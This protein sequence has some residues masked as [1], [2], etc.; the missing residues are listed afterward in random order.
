MLGKRFGKL[1]VQE[2]I[3][4]HPTIKRDGVYRCLCDCGTVCEARAVSLRKGRK[5]S[6][7]CLAAVFSVS[8]WVGKKVGQLQVLE[9]LPGKK[10]RCLCDCGAE[11]VSTSMWSRNKTGDANCRGSAHRAP[12]PVKPERVAPPSAGDHWLYTTWASMKARCLSPSNRNYHR[13]GGRGIQVCFEWVQSFWAYAVYVETF[14][15]P[16]PVEGYSLDR[17]E[18]DGN[19]EPGNLRWASPLQQGRNRSDT[20]VTEYAGRTYTTRAEAYAQWCFDGKPVGSVFSFASEQLACRQ[21]QIRDAREIQKQ[22][23]LHAR[24]ALVQAHLDARE[25]AKAER[26]VRDKFAESKR[27]AEVVRSQG[28]AVVR[29]TDDAVLSLASGESKHYR[30]LVFF[31]R[32]WKFPGGLW[33]QRLEGGKRVLEIA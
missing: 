22:M 25:K 5:K 9:R 1:V 21:A 14:L 17:K 29:T 4:S 19:Y 8:P 13:Y 2:K 26:V 33:S 20:K 3:S 28:G 16:R 6:C 12:K 32:V 27:L 31:D 18:N 11:I 7:G 15:G 30:N 24:R 10:Y 23:T